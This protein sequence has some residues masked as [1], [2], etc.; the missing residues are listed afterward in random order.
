MKHPLLLLSLASIAFIGPNSEALLSNTTSF[1]MNDAGYH[2]TSGQQY[3]QI[4]IT[5]QPH[6]LYIESCKVNYQKNAGT[7]KTLWSDQR[8]AINC[9]AKAE[10]L[11]LRLKDR[12]WKCQIAG[13]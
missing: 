2:C 9:E 3:R 8:N 11:A 5:Y 12:G 10:L 7:S 4:N 6:D 13:I 1:D